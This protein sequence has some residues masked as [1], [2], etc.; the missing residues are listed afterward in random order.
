MTVL[1]GDDTQLALT[2]ASAFYPGTIYKTSFPALENNGFNAGYFYTTSTSGTASLVIYDSNGNL[3]AQSAEVTLSSTVTGWVPCTFSQVYFLEF[4][5]TYKLGVFSAS[6][7]DLG[8][9]GSGST[10]YISVPNGDYPTAPS[11]LAGLGGGRISSSSNLSVYLEVDAALPTVTTVNSALYAPT[12][13]AVTSSTSGGTL[14]SGTYTYVVTAYDASGETSRSNP[15]VVNVASGSTNSNSMSW[16]AIP[17]A[18]GYKVYSQYIVIGGLNHFWYYDVGD[19]TSYTDTGATPTG[20]ATAP[21]TSTA[22]PVIADGATSIPLVGTGFVA[23]MTVA[24]TQPNGISVAQANVA[25]TSATAATF[26][27]VI[28][29]AS[30]EQLAFTDST[31]VTNLVVTVNGQSGAPTPVTIPPAGLIFQ[32][33]GTLHPNPA[34]RISALPDL[35]PGDQLEAA[36]DSTGTTAPP[37][38]TVLHSDGSFEA[39]AD[40]YVRAYIQADAAWTPWTLITVSPAQPGQGFFGGGGV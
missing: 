34:M 4:G 3:V 28:E 6:T 31:Y 25:V 22:G 11:T 26:D 5:I 21:Q 39:S 27:A 32:T 35:V 19:V 24:L 1:A 30:G 2:G 29:P 7:L 17:G 14:A 13:G 37:A 38:G 33:L 18:A 12:L 15:Q 40:F 9:G 8:L 10:S 36:G 23:G 20:I 16:S